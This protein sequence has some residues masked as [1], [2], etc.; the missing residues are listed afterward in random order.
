MHEVLWLAKFRGWLYLYGD[1]QH[2][3]DIMELLVKVFYESLTCPPRFQQSEPINF[4]VNH[5]GRPTQRLLQSGLG[6][7]FGTSISAMHVGGLNLAPVSESSAAG[8]GLNYS[9][10]CLA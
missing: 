5:H 9:T 6:F 3:P 10:T 2:N 7:E 8:P 1:H 4:A